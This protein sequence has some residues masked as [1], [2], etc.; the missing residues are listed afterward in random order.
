MVVVIVFLNSNH[1]RFLNK[2]DSNTTTTNCNGNNTEKLNHSNHGILTLYG[3]D[4][5]G[6]RIRERDPG[7]RGGGNRHRA[8]AVK[9]GAVAGKII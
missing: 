4:G 3:E 6:T 5:P 2:T 9:A 8:K 1:H 7:R